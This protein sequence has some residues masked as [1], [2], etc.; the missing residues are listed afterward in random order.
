VKSADSLRKAAPAVEMSLNISPN[1]A[2]V[3]GSIRKFNKCKHFYTSEHKHLSHKL[4]IIHHSWTRSYQVLHEARIPSRCRS[5]QARILLQTM[6]QCWCGLEYAFLLPSSVHGKL[7]KKYIN[8]SKYYE[9]K[10]NE[11]AVI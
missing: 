7:W 2:D 8:K 3:W 10:W 6:W 9:M 1:I 11:S 4:N 5:D